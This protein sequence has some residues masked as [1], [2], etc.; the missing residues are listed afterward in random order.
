M[1]NVENSP[2]VH[3]PKWRVAAGFIVAPFVVATALA[4]TMP[5]YAGLPNLLDRVIRTLPWYLIIGGYIP[6]LLLGVPLYLLLRKRVA[7]T[8]L[9]CLIAGAAVAA[10]PCALL[11]LPTFST[12]ESL[13]SQQTV[14]DGHKTLLGWM[15]LAQNIGEMALLG[16]IAGTVFWLVAAAGERQNKGST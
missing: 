9:N 7:P 15:Y 4:W 6:S 12:E 3:L 14:I 8:L 11:G 5:L 13:G 10:I 1:E 16:G 2:Y